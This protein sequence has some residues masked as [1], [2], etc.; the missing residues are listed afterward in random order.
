MNY[1]IAVLAGA[2]ALGAGAGGAEKR[3]GDYSFVFPLVGQVPDD[4]QGVERLD[5][6]VANGDPTGEAT[7]QRLHLRQEIRLRQDLSL[8]GGDDAG[9]VH[10]RVPDGLVARRDRI[11]QLLLE[12]L[13]RRHE[14]SLI[15][16]GPGGR[17]SDGPPDPQRRRDESGSGEA[18]SDAHGSLR[19][20][21]PRRQGH[22][23]GPEASALVASFRGLSPAVRGSGD[24]AR[25]RSAGRCRGPG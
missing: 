25:A 16:V 14:R 22:V 2:L 21:Y 9:S 12:V 15:V 24:P 5:G 4:R 1:R 10:G 6:Q 8:F 7:R 17:P 3:L 19:Q 13:K 18:R 20:A 23:R 11:H